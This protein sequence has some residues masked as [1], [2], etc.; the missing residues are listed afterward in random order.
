LKVIVLISECGIKIAIILPLDVKYFIYFVWTIF[1]IY[2]KSSPI[3]KNHRQGI[4][5]AGKI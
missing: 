1:K 2:F 3:L 4:A 5:E